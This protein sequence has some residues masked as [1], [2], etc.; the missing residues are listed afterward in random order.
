MASCHRRDPQKLAPLQSLY[1]EQY[2]FECGVDLY[3]EAVGLLQPDHF[4][5]GRPRC[6]DLVDLF[7]V[8]VGVGREPEG[9]VA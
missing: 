9:S 5:H 8:Y 1:A 2:R 4:Q 3:L 6:W 7:G